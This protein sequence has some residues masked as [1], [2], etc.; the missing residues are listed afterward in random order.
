MR[1]LRETRLVLGYELGKTRRRPVWA[2]FGLTQPLLWLA[3]FTPLLD[4][5]AAPGLRRGGALEFFVPGLLLLLILY[6]A[7]FVGY[8]LLA[9]VRAGVVERLAVTPASRLALV[10]GR[11]AH[12]LVVVVAQALVLLALAVP[13]GLRPSPAGTAAFLVLVGLAGVAAASFSYVIALAV[14][15][16]NAMASTLNF[17]TLP[18]L[19]LSGVLLPL[20]L[21]PR[22]LRLLA[23]A[24]PLSHA[25]EAGRDLLGGQLAAGSVAVAFALTTGLA[26]VMVAW[27]VRGYQRDPV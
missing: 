6:G 26:A 4:R 11:V 8:G 25:A 7:M 2:A 10:L 19:L 20:D 5:V 13:A 18:L 9:Q 3:L 17:L 12:D 23:A 1:P 24:N 21:A 22:W 14:R 15:D 16:E 27:L